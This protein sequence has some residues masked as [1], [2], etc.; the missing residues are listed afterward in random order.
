M[1]NK[2]VKNSPV[3]SVTVKEAIATIKKGQ[4]LMHLSGR[5]LHLYYLEK[6]VNKQKEITVTLIPA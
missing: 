6:F 5:V 2:N 4:R 1:K 3:K